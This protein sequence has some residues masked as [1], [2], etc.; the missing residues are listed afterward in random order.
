MPSYVDMCFSSAEAGE[1]DQIMRV[2][3][4][5]FVLMKKLVLQGRIPAAFRKRMKLGHGRRSLKKAQKVIKTAKPKLAPRGKRQRRSSRRRRGRSSSVADLDDTLAAAG[6]PLA[7]EE[8][9]DDEEEDSYE[10]LDTRSARRAARRAARHASAVQHSSAIMAALIEGRIPTSHFESDSD[11]EE[12]SD[13]DDLPLLQQL[14]GDAD[15]GFNELSRGLSMRRR[16]S[17]FA[18]PRRREAEAELSL[19]LQSARTGRAEED[20]RRLS[21]SE[22]ILRFAF[23]YGAEERLPCGLTRNQVAS[24]MTRDIT[25]EDYTMLQSLD[26]SQASLPTLAEDDPSSEPSAPGRKKP[27][28]QAHFDQLQQMTGGSPALKYKTNCAICLLAVSSADSVTVLPCQHAY[29]TECARKWL[30]QT[31][32]RCPTCMADITCPCVASSEC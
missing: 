15:S 1:E 6:I 16:R 12:D 30:L 10:V 31:D 22:S 20:R 21:A 19:I 14:G 7:H 26:E 8:E 18:L 3:W 17:G 13:M 25:P 11:S 32:R 4:R 23:Q 29:H 28:S 24:L 9:E 2:P 27:A 5:R